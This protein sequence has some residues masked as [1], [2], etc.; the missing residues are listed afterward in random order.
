VESPAERA[1]V[2]TLRPRF[3]LLDVARQLDKFAA[4]GAGGRRSRLC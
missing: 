2:V 1:L 4:G 3:E